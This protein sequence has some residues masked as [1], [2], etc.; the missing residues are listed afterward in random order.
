[1]I[2][3]TGSSKYWVSFGKYKHQFSFQIHEMILAKYST[4]YFMFTENMVCSLY[5]AIQIM[6]RMF[7]FDSQNIIF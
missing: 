2:S 7:H 5:A 3:N 1:M 4:L 6:K